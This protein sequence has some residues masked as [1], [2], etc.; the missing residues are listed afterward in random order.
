MKKYLIGI[1]TFVAIIVLPKLSFAATAFNFTDGSTNAT[2]GSSYGLSFKIGQPS[3]TGSGATNWV[4]YFNAT[5]TDGD[6]AHYVADLVEFNDSAYSSYS[7]DWIIARGNTTDTTEMWNASGTFNGVTLNTSKWYGLAFYNSQGGTHFVTVKAEAGSAAGTSI[8]GFTGSLWSANPQF[9][10]G[11]TN[12][13]CF[14]APPTTPTINFLLPT[15][16]STQPQSNAFA[17]GYSNLIATHTY[18]TIINWFLPQVSPQ[19]TTSLTAKGANMVGGVA[20]PETP[21]IKWQASAGGIATSSWVAQAYL[22]DITDFRIPMSLDAFLEATTSVAWYQITNGN[23]TNATTSYWLVSVSGTN[24]VSTTTIQNPTV[25]ANTFISTST[26]GLQCGNAPGITDIP[27][28]LVWAG[29][30]LANFLFVPTADISVITQSIQQI[31]SSFP[32]GLVFNLADNTQNALDNASS[33][34][35]HDLIFTLPAPFDIS[36]PLLTSTTLESAVGSTTKS[37]IFTTE[38][39]LIWIGAAIRILFFLI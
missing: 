3:I 13:D 31:K 36:V 21:Q 34:A 32:F 18:Q 6:F 39:S 8:P 16:G 33:S 38:R 7:Q 17:V 28:G 11:E 19:F 14:T 26:F 37:T 24:I 15:N 22:Y 10:L 29:C 23:F 12:G 30:S 4:W 27:G 35:S 5:T 20:I 9:C 2:N 25:A 1:I